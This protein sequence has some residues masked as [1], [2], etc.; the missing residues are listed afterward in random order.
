MK[1]HIKINNIFKKIIRI[2]NKSILLIL[3]HWW[4][5]L[6]TI[7]GILKFFLYS[8]TLT[9]VLL[10]Q[11]LEINKDTI[12]ITKDSIYIDSLSTYYFD[13]KKLTITNPEITF[14]K[15]MVNGKLKHSINLSMGEIVSTTK[16]LEY[17]LI[18]LNATKIKF[19]ELSLKNIPHNADP[20]VPY[21]ILK[22]VYYILNNLSINQKLIDLELY[23]FTLNEKTIW[24]KLILDTKNKTVTFENKTLLSK[25]LIAIV[26][27]TKENNI[28][29]NLTL[30]D[31]YNKFNTPIYIKTIHNIKEFSKFNVEMIWDN[32]AN[33]KGEILEENDGLILKP[34]RIETTFKHSFNFIEDELNQHLK[35]YLDNLKFYYEDDKMDI[36]HNNIIAFIV[37]K[38]EIEIKTLQPLK[39]YNTTKTIG[40]KL[41]DIN[42]SSSKINWVAIFSTINNNFETN[43]ITENTYFNTYYIDKTLIHIDNKNDEKLTFHIKSDTN[44]TM[45]FDV[46]VFQEEKNKFNTIKTIINKFKWNNSIQFYDETIDI[47]IDKSQL[48]FNTNYGKILWK[49]K[50]IEMNLTYNHLIKLLKKH[51]INTEYLN[52]SINKIK[53]MEDTILPFSMIKY[54]ILSQDIPIINFKINNESKSINWVL[55]K[56]IM[57]EINIDGNLKYFYKEDNLILNNEIF[58]HTPLKKPI[59]AI[60]FNDIETINIEEN[61]KIKDANIAFDIKIDSNGNTFI[62]NSIVNINTHIA[63]FQFENIEIKKEDNKTKIYMIETLQGFDILLGLNNN[64]FEL[65][66]LSNKNPIKHNMNILYIGNI[67]IELNKGTLNIRKYDNRYLING[68]IN[69]YLNSCNINTTQTLLNNFKTKLYNK[70]SQK[71]IDYIDM[72]I[73]FNFIYEQQNNTVCKISIEDKYI[74]INFKSIIINYNSKLKKLLGKIEIE[75]GDFLYKDKLFYLMGSH[76]D[77][78]DNKKIVNINA[79]HT[80]RTLNQEDIKID[81]NTFGNI[82]NTMFINVSSNPTRNEQTLLNYLIFNNE[83]AMEEESS[84]NGEESNVISNEIINISVKQMK[85]FLHL[86]VDK[87]SV[88]LNSKNMNFNTSTSTYKVDKKLTKDIKVSYIQSQE[89]STIKTNKNIIENKEIDVSYKIN[90]NIR[91]LGYTNENSQGIMFEW[92]KE[93]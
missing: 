25:P 20:N 58:I 50:T 11:L 66:Q 31:M 79:N 28:E 83:E 5:I 36:I 72:D 61:I 18:Q 30:N 15:V 14:N 64:N 54:D 43:I 41:G 53:T 17:P 63:S 9:I 6:I 34:N 76:I 90:K 10:F 92:Q 1:T 3:L 71:S 51:S 2:F 74:N 42:I 38:N 75:N 39:H 49:D 48:T 77:L 46:K 68:D 81:I 60:N 93:Y 78:I 37:K 69:V 33:I 21:N 44:S 40:M 57:N 85:N 45:D 19:E 7:I 56:E 8:F 26:N 62:D 13:I 27:L 59:K 32:I 65:M 82:E 70:I 73:L 84:D 52:N 86:P 29:L 23:N 4:D 55:N 35:N 89:N 12:I 24:D 16:K 47:A 88:K 80:Y 91:A 22:R 67:G 87:I